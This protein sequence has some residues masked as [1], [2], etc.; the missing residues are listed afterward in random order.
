MRML[1]S[2]GCRAALTASLMIGL[3]APAMAA[4]VYAYVTEEGTHAF[5]DDPKRIPAKYKDAAERRTMGQLKRYE[6]WTP[7]D[8]ASD[9]A[10]V[11]RLPDHLERL[12]EANAGAAYRAHHRGMYGRHHGKRGVG[13]FLTL[14][15]GGR[16]RGADINV[17]FGDGDGPIE[18]ETQRV[19]P[20]SWT[21]GTATRSVTVVRRDG[22]VIA[23]V[24]P[25]RNM[26]PTSEA[27]EEDF[28]R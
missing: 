27:Y 12:R 17:P 8:R 10:Y 9:G 5:T 21:D 26:R 14:R 24:K 23:V 18:V 20:K 11:D 28:E 7:S 4:T 22:E 3:A 1:I 2:R 13:D 15:T 6:R 16:D 19:K 25:E